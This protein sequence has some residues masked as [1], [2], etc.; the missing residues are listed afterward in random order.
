MD[1]TALQ[2]FWILFP[3]AAALF[4][5]SRLAVTKRLS[6]DFS[7]RTLTLYVNLASLVVTLP[8]IVWYHDIPLHEPIYLLVVLAGAVLSG[9]GGWSLNAGI[10]RGDVSVVG[11]TMT[12]T[13]AFVVLIEWLLTGNLPGLPGVAGLAVLVSGS[14]LISVQRP[15][16]HWY[17][18][19]RRLFLEPGSALA[20]TAALCFAAASTLGRIGIGMSDPLSFAVVVAVINP[21]ILVIIFSSQDKH[22]LRDALPPD[23]GRHAPAL[24]LL[25]VLFALMRIADQIAL[26]LTL[27]S[28][29]MTVKRSG[30]VISVLLG[31]WYFREGSL[32]TRLAG[33]LVML[34]GLML[35]ISD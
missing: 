6:F 26:S 5:A 12:L 23:L 32:A 2:P 22:F 15:I 8:L 19:L 17:D 7:A 24:I 4:Q 10:K 27:A 33:S 1:L 20:L 11:P 34:I 25:G 31:H 9:L 30:G 13:P 16:P 3:L 21:L 18:P 29:A 14:W 28:Y 35:L